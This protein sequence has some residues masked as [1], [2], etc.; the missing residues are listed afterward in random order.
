M[1]IFSSDSGTWLSF[2]SAQQLL[3]AKTSGLLA[4]PAS[5]AETSSVN[6]AMELL[7]ERNVQ[8]QRAIGNIRAKLQAN[9]FKSKIPGRSLG[10]QLRHVVHLIAAG[11]DAPVYKVSP[12]SYTHLTLPTNYSV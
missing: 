12:V 10:K 4:V 8:L 5:S 7:L 6:P 9:R 11:V 2:E 1:N 3:K